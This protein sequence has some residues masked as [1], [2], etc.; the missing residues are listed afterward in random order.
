MLFKVLAFSSLQVEP[1]IGN[2]TDVRKKCLNKWVEFILQKMGK[3]NW[4]VSLISNAKKGEKQNKRNKRK[5][6]RHNLPTQQ[7]LLKK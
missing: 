2:C 7:N 5:K 4:T 6:E 3:K 1:S